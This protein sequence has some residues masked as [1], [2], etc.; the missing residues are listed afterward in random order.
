MKHNDMLYGANDFRN[1]ELYHHGIKGQRWGERRFQYEDGSLTPDG[2]KRY[3]VGEARE[4]GWIYSIKKTAQNAVSSIVD[5]DKLKE[6]QQALDPVA[7]KK[8]IGEINKKS[9]E[10][11]RKEITPEDR[12]SYRKEM[13]KRGKDSD[14]YKNATDD[15]I[16]AD[17]EKKQRIKKAIIVGA[18]AVG[19]GAACYMAYRSGVFDKMIGEINLK[20]NLSEDDLRKAY[21]MA[22]GKSLDDIGL[23]LNKNTTLHRMVGYKDFDLN[24]VNGPLYAAYKDTDVATY[25]VFLKDFLGTGQRYDVSLGIKKNLVAP[26][27][28]K[29]QEIISDLFKNDKDFSQDLAKTIMNFQTNGHYTQY[30]LNQLIAQINGSNDKWKFDQVIWGIARND[31]M[32]G[33]AMD[34]FRN[35]GFNAIIDFHDKDAPISEMPLILLNGKTDLV[36]KGQ[37]FVNSADKQRAVDFLKKNAGRMDPK[38]RRTLG[39]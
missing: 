30:Q 5:P 2:R 24:K 15:E 18:A 17:I 29:T 25:K 3:G 21:S 36:K 23:V 1:F 6:A 11:R 22:K 19:V 10:E 39:L 16:D 32:A 37:Q 14:F 38:I 33:K 26:S 31:K 9:F 27:R 34:A 20:R 13:I 35:E 12:D 8:Y 28:D 4:S 7:L